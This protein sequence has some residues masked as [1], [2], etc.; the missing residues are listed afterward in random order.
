MP[1]FKCM[2]CR[3]RID[4]AG[5]R[6]RCCPECGGVLVAAPQLTELV[7]FR[8]PDLRA[9]ETPHD[10]RVADITAR[11]R[12]A[13]GETWLMAATQELALPESRYRR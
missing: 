2:P 8:T 1:Y 6:G 11:R 13:R 7:G 9:E 12:A 4:F 10:E 5:P 3:I